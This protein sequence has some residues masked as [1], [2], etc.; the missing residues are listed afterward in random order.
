MEIQK[1]REVHEES[2]RQLF[3]NSRIERLEIQNQTQPSNE[4]QQQ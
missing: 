1:I 2:Q 3:K 4:G